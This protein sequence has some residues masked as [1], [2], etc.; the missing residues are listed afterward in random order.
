MHHLYPT[1]ASDTKSL[2]KLEQYFNAIW[3]GHRD[4]SGAQKKAIAFFSSLMDDEGPVIKWGSHSNRRRQMYVTL[5]DV[6]VHCLA[7]RLLCNVLVNAFWW[8]ILRTVP[9]AG[10]EP[11]R[12]HLYACRFRRLAAA[13]HEP[14]AYVDLLMC[15][16]TKRSP[17]R[18]F[19]VTKLRGY[20]DF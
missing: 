17:G 14:F 18:D 2:H 4:I 15:S 16:T 19:D 3:S 6:S 7:M 13:R 5:I 12:G 11:S 20:A 9:L 10:F 1:E 8:K